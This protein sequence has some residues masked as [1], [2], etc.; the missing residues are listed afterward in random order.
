MDDSPKHPYM[1]LRE[2]DYAPFVESKGNGSFRADYLS[3]S[4][5][6]D[7]IK[8]IDPNASYEVV[9][10]ETGNGNP[11]PYIMCEKGAL[12][13][14]RLRYADQNEEIQIHNEYL[15]VTDHRMQCVPV[16]DSVQVVNTV[17]RCV[18]KAV[19]MV[20]GF[21]I[22]LWFGEDIKGLDY[23]PQ[24][25]LDGTVPRNGEMTVEQGVKLDRLVRNR[26]ITKDERAK[27]KSWIAE[28]PTEDDAKGQIKR[29]DETIKARKEEKKK[30]KE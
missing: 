25:R 30:E 19:S 13:H 27:L 2:D 6:W 23:R 21:G 7:K 1:V 26:L 20:T 12:I 22:E 15:A 16:P 11:I 24:T 29:L 3:W 18:A 17:R 10:Y 5:C 28:I 9:T 8:Q 14:V 4:V